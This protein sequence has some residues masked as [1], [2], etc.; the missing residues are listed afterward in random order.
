MKRKLGY[1]YFD[2]YSDVE[3]SEEVRDFLTK[4]NNYNSNFW[5]KVRKNESVF[6]DCG[7]D[8]NGDREYIDGRD[9][10]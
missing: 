9:I 3:M 10:E 4:D 1:D 2:D 7:L 6:S 8:N 5:R